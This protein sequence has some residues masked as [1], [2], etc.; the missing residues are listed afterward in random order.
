M[1]KLLVINILLIILQNQ[2]NATVKVFINHSPTDFFVRVH[3]NKDNTIGITLAPGAV[4]DVF[5]EGD[6]IDRIIIQSKKHGSRPLAAMN[7]QTLRHDSH[8]INNYMIFIINQDSSVKMYKGSTSRDM[9][10]LK[11]DAA[12]TK[13]AKL[14]TIDMAIHTTKGDQYWTAQNISYDIKYKK[15]FLNSVQSLFS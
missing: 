3:D 1:K 14:P 5:T 13:H 10:L 4:Q 15:S 12:Y 9:T 7:N 6:M 11:I 8:K 2:I